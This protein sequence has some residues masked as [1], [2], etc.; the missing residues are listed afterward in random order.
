MPEL[1]LGRRQPSIV[2]FA[3][4]FPRGRLGGP[5]WL[6]RAVP[7]W[8]RIEREVI[9]W[10]VV[11]CDLSATECLSEFADFRGAEGLLKSRQRYDRWALLLRRRAARLGE[12]ALASGARC[13]DRSHTYCGKLGRVPISCAAFSVI[14]WVLVHRVRSGSSFRRTQLTLRVLVRWLKL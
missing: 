6:G 7:V 2:V 9:A 1:E 5:L 8:E 3:F 12:E 10:S 13:L 4:N 14:W 11:V